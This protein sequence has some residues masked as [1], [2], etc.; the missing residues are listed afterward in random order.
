M[1]LQAKV[2]QVPYCRRRHGQLSGPGEG[3]MPP[4]QRR[5]FLGSRR[6]RGVELQPWGGGG[7]GCER[8]PRRRPWRY[9]YHNAA[10]SGS[11]WRRDWRGQ[12]SQWRGGGRRLSG[13]QERRSTAIHDACFV[14]FFCPP[15]YGWYYYTNLR[16]VFFYM[17]G[18]VS[19]KRNW[20]FYPLITVVNSI[21]KALILKNALTY[22]IKNKQYDFFFSNTLNPIKFALFPEAPVSSKQ[23]A[24]STDLRLD[25]STNDLKQVYTSPEAISQK[26]YFLKN[27]HLKI[28]YNF[29]KKSFCLK[30]IQYLKIAFYLAKW[31]I[32]KNL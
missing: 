3:G 30:Q 9:H 8:L 6:V 1:E 4:Q 11:G 5:G 23:G 24:C 15:A 19:E 29:Q 12:R 26:T 32:F 27:V 13:N 22:L 21:A 10:S 16:I 18:F 7:E 20:E 14:L 17:K 2:D 25:T 31:P 28:I